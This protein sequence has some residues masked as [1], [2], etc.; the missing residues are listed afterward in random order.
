MPEIVCKET[1]NK[2]GLY[3]NIFV[4]LFLLGKAVWGE[5]PSGCHCQHTSSLWK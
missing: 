1:E 5:N 3:S 2:T 4:L